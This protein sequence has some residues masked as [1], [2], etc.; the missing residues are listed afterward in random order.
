MERAREPLGIPLLS[1]TY[2]RPFSA[3]GSIVTLFVTYPLK[4]PLTG[5]GSACS[6]VC[7]SGS[8][9]EWGVLPV[10][11]RVIARGA[12]VGAAREESKTPRKYEEGSIRI[13]I[14]FTILFMVITPE[15][16]GLR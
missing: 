2:G 3:V 12:V 6:G 13:R 14:R 11:P 15:K 10:Y 9:A 1:T 8:A 16:T 5:P 4:S 7:G